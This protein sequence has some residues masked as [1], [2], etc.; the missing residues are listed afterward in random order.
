[1]GLREPA[2]QRSPPGS[3]GTVTFKYDPFGRRVYKSSSAGTS[4][5][6]YDGDN[7]VEETNA[8]GGVV[9][10]Y[11]QTQNID[12]TLAMLRSSTWQHIGIVDPIEHCRH[13][14]LPNL[15]ARLMNSGKRHREKLCVFHVINTHDPE[16]RYPSGLQARRPCVLRKRAAKLRKSENG[17][18]AKQP[19][20]RYRTA[21]PGTSVPF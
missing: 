1:L 3:G 8:S 4:I 11:T 9:A 7:Q 20:R 2:Y 14:G 6:V 17:P 13:G 18:Q 15:A 12:E 5:Y 10:R 21:K 16:K 19:Q